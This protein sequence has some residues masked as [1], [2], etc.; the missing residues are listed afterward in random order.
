MSRRVESNCLNVFSA[1]FFA[2]L[3]LVPWSIL[4]LQSLFPS[5][6][7]M[8]HLPSERY[9]A[10]LPLWGHWWHTACV[11]V[12]AIT[13]YSVISIPFLGSLTRWFCSFPARPC[14]VFTLFVMSTVCV[15]R[16]NAL[17]VNAHSIFRSLFFHQRAKQQARFV[18]EPEEGVRWLFVGFLVSVYV[19]SFHCW[20]LA[21]CEQ[22]V[23]YGSAEFSACLCSWPIL[24][25]FGIRHTHCYSLASYDWHYAFISVELRT[26]VQFVVLCGRLRFV[27]WTSLALMRWYFWLFLSVF[28]S[29][30]IVSFSSRWFVPSG[31]W[32]LA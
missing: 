13:L 11:P 12:L 1:S 18:F 20:W 21:E 32:C 3:P 17:K 10:S 14:L 2:T 4:V 8:N 6:S 24:F 26:L 25:S 27:G 9:H 29:T 19:C 7:V 28:P 16:V 30:R 22:T 15:P 31:G 23:P 5:P